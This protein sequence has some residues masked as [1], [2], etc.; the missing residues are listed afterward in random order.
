MAGQTLQ[1]R[2]AEAMDEIDEDMSAE[3]IDG[4]GNEDQT[5]EE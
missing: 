1:I 4:I 5:T 2:I 3:E